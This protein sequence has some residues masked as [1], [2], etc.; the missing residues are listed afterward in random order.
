VRVTELVLP[1]LTPVELALDQV[2][3]G[4]SVE[5]MVERPAGGD[6]PDDQDSLAGPTGGY[7]SEEPDRPLDGLL[8]AFT[9]RIGVG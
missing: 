1:S 9:V 6:V 7:I 8:P 4:S 5:E 3:E 2:F